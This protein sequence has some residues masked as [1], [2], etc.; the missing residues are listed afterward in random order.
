MWRMSASGFLGIIFER[1]EESI[2]QN[3]RE[4]PLTPHHRHLAD[5]T[6][7]LLSLNDPEGQKSEK[8]GLMGRKERCRT[9]KREEKCFFVIMLGH[10]HTDTKA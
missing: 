1:E 10:D 6:N 8:R 2:R 5:K 9:V 3:W 4:P 7:K